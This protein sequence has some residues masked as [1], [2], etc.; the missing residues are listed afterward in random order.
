MTK[1]PKLLSSIETPITEAQAESDE[2][3]SK[4]H[5]LEADNERLKITLTEH[6]LINVQFEIVCPDASVNQ[7]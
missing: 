2:E 5:S 1:R 3:L 4:Q 7:R 6:A